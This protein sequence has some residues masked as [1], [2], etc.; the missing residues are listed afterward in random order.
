M[1]GQNGLL[2]TFNMTA[3]AT[4]FLP[5]FTSMIASLVSGEEIRWWS[6]GRAEELGQGVTLGFVY[7]WSLLLFG[8][9]VWYGGNRVLQNDNKGQLKGF[10][11]TLI[12]FTNLALMLALL[13]SDLGVSVSWLIA[14]CHGHSPRLTQSFLRCKWRVKRRKKVVG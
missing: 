4:V 2:L 8:G 12:L 1:N 13:T 10:L 3:G 14:S 9:I 7:F 5:L 6:W 11:V